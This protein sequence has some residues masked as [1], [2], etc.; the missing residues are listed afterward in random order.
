MSLW[1]PPK[2]RRELRDSTAA[3]TADVM[4]MVDRFKG[5]MDQYNRMLKEIDPHLELIFAKPNARAPGLVPGRY[6]V[7]RHIPG[8]PPTLLPVTGPNGEFVEPDSGVFEALAR[9]DLWNDRQTQ[10]QRRNR[11]AAE[12]ARDRQR[13]HEAQERQSELAERWAA[14][15]RAQVSMNRS[16]PWSQNTSGRRGARS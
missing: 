16:A 8:G 14:V 6:H 12:R 2:V 7:M 9:S 5:F 13:A 15:S 3:H 4:A 11:E 10:D 1:V